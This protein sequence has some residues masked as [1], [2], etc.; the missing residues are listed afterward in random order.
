[1]SSGIWTYPGSSGLLRHTLGADDLVALNVV[2]LRQGPQLLNDALGEAPGVTVNALVD[3]L[4]TRELF[5]NEG[6]A[7]VQ[8][9]EEVEVVDFQLFRNI[10]LK[11]NDVRVVQAAMGVLAGNEWGQ[12]QGRVTST[13][14]WVCGKGSCGGGGNESA[15][16]QNQP[17]ETR[18]GSGSG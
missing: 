9:L 14:V 5:T 3:P 8:S 18:H 1:M 7:G 4:N 11:H 12:G 10:V 16:D 2:D 17:Q 13:G 15:G 6:V